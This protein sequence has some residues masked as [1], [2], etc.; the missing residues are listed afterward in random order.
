[1]RGYWEI[2]FVKLYV[3]GKDIQ[4]FQDL[5]ETSQEHISQMIKEGYTS[6]ELNEEGEINEGR[7]LQS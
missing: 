1:M 3:E 2:K 4:D 7:K 6:G 5:S